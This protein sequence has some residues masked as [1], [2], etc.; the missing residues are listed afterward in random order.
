LRC[1]GF[2][3]WRVKGLSSFQQS[4]L[5]RNVVSRATCCLRAAGWEDLFYI[6]VWFIC[7]FPYLIAL[8]RKQERS[9]ENIATC[10]I[11]SQRLHF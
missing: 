11:A 3:E 5:K 6:S 9:S 1:L 2:I 7:I 4:S 10:L 8:C